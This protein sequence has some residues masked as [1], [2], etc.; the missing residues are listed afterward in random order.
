MFRTLILTDTAGRTWLL[1]PSVGSLD[2][3]MV[4]A[5]LEIFPASRVECWPA[6]PKEGD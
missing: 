3:A 6:T 5:L 2:A 1:Y 4:L